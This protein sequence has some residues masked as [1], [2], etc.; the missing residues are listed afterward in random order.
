MHLRAATFAVLLVGYGCSDECVKLPD[1]EPMIEIGTGWETFIPIGE[2]TGF[3][4]GPQG[5][6]HVYASLRA[7]G[8][9][10]GDSDDLRNTMPSLTY[11]VESLDGALTGGFSNM[12]RPMDQL[13]DGRAERLGDLAILSSYE[14]SE[15]EGVEVTISAEIKDT[16]GRRAISTARTI[17]SEGAF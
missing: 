3:E 13:D 7:T 4:K 2:V 15:M 14:A 16:C 11:R 10:G 5:G 12:R 9:F 8:I 17:L 1:V 6:F